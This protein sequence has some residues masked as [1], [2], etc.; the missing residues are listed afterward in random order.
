MDRAT[1]KKLKERKEK[2]DASKKL[3]QNRNSYSKTDKDAFFMC[4]TII[5]EIYS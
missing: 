1:K 5:C 2:Y 3:M 4:K